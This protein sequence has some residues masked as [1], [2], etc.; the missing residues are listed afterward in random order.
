MSTLFKIGLA[1]L[2]LVECSNHKGHFRL[3]NK[4]SEPLQHVNVNVCGQSISADNVLPLGEMVGD[5]VVKS[6][7][8]YSVQIEFKSGKKLQ[9]DIG[10][11]TNGV[12][13]NHEITVTDGDLSISNTKIN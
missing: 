3:L 10:Y 13:F 9:K 11:I 6:D 8:H 7:S 4:A 1:A 5:F 12:D 2:V